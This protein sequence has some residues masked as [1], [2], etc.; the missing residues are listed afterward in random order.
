[1]TTE[2]FVS[3]VPLP[4]FGLWGKLPGRRVPLSF[5]LEI[6]ARCNNACRHCYINLPAGDL[7]ARRKE[8]S[9]AEINDIAD[10]AVGL[11]ALW[12][13]IS[14]GEPLL[15]DDF[16]DIY[17]SLKQKGLLVSVFTNACLVTEEHVALFTKYPPRDLEVTVYGI[18]PDTYER[19]TQR[20]GSYIAF[21]RGLDLLL[22]NELKVRLKAMA[23]RSNVSELPAIAAF[24]RENTI[25]YF[26][27]D[28]QLHLRYD[29]NQK[30]NEEI[31][32]ERLSP[33]EIVKIEQGDDE[34]ARALEKDCD[35]LIFSEY[36]G[37]LCDHLFHCGAGNQNFA[38]SYDGIFRLC[39]DLWHPDCIYDLRQGKLSQAWDEL[40]PR[41]RDLRSTNPTFLEQ[42]RRC[43]IINLCLWCPAHAHLECAQ[44][45][46]WSEY[47][48]QVA[49]ARAEAISSS[50]PSL[51]SDSSLIPRDE[52]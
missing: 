15:R 9:L 35:R 25:D 1:M 33:G 14:G 23:L 37:H 43:P 52:K 2:S 46:G 4:E 5:D 24:C 19:V 3:S 32:A 50:H 18:T 34:R 13:L 41:V 47:F 10:Q 31:K 38:V 40:V 11:G 45:D 30:R 49:H 12:C 6:T 8:L 17:I 36:E 39:A 26:R 27:F 51:H 42:C 48:C 7:E 29:H 20:P 21:R 28:P 16:A 44:M 22:K